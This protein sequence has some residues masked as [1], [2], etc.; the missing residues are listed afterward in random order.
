[1]SKHAKD[2]SPPASVANN[3]GNRPNWANKGESMLKKFMPYIVSAALA[4]AAFFSGAVTDTG[5]AVKIAINKDEA[6]KT[7]KDLINGNAAPV[8]PAPAPAP[9]P[10]SAPAVIPQ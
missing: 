5:S 6:V 3:G 10:A 8:T 9:A 4:L 2:D 1:M 7:C